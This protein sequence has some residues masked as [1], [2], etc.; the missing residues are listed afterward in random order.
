MSAKAKTSATQ[1]T[2][3][4]NVSLQWAFESGPAAAASRMR[5]RVAYVAYAPFLYGAERSLQTMLQ[6][7]PAVGIDPLV[8]SPPDSA[9][10]PWCESQGVRFVSSILPVRDKWHPYRWWSTVARLQAICRQ[11]K[12]QVVHANQVFSYPAIGLAAKR[13]RIPRVCHLRNDVTSD[14]VDWWLA[15]GAEAVICVSQYIADQFCRFNTKQI[16][17]YAYVDAVDFDSSPT[18]LAQ[19]DRQRAA[20]QKLRAPSNRTVLGYI[21]QLV[22]VKGVLTLIEALG[23]IASD[24]RWHLIIAG[25]DPSP[26]RPYEAQCRE[27]IH[28]Y[29]LSDRICFAGF[30]DDSS[31]FYGAVDVVIVPSLVEPLGRIPLEAAVHRKPSIASETG[32]LPETIVNGKTGWLV[33]PEDSSAL[34]RAITNFLDCPR[35]TQGEAARA[36]VEKVA[37]PSPY[38]ARLAS[39][40]EGL[41]AGRAC[42]RG[43]SEDQA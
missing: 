24:Q 28:R 36:W 35:S 40:Y 32:G 11:H 25:A 2:W 34:A 5:M 29:G 18:T 16:P 22:P 9:L 3:D 30:L 4:R 14:M 7:A 17:S 31:L 23:C 13:L 26:G 15:D 38:M 39:I 41:L 1:D 42:A 27:L 19:I 37:S 21:G 8:I 12:V 43:P 6:F 20:Q 10:G 33:P